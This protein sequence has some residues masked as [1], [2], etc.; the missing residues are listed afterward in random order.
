MRTI[1]RSRQATAALP[2]AMVLSCVTLPVAAAASGSSDRE[3]DYALSLYGGTQTA[4]NRH[5]K[6]HVDDLCEAGAE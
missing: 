6:T 2:A 5:E 1:P 3:R 4:E